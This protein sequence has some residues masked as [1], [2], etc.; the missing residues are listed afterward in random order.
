MPNL[1]TILAELHYV[2]QWLDYGLLS[3]EFWQNQYSRYQASDDKNTEHYRF[4]AFQAVLLNH[5]MLDG[6]AL[7][8]Y[9]ELAMA[10]PDPSMGGSALALLIHWHGLTDEQLHQ[11]VR[12]PAYN[13]PF[14]QKLLQQVMM[15]RELH[16]TGI[17]EESFERFLGSQDA[18]IHR[19]LLSDSR[20][21]AEH[22]QLLQARGANRAIRNIAKQKLQRT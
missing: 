22:L 18:V 10:D 13:Q 21:K 7:N 16:S 12:H 8:H 3:E 6:A 17:N 14:L 15:L 5:G 11:L 2:P 1:R 19:A 9:I 20:I 4:E